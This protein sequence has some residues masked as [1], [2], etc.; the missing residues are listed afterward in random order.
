MTVSADKAT[1]T[2]KKVSKKSS[3]PSMAILATCPT[4]GAGWCAF[5]FSP[6]QLEKRMKTKAQ[7]NQLETVSK[8]KPQKKSK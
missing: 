8:K 7:L 5:P 6:K 2:K 3:K 1:T 4:N